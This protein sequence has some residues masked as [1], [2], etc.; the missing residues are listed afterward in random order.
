MKCHLWHLTGCLEQKVSTSQ[1]MRFDCL[2]TLLLT[3]LPQVWPLDKKEY[4]KI[5]STKTD[6][7]GTQKNLLDEK[8]LLNIQD[9]CLK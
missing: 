9:K 1:V 8:V 6:I 3:H 4:L 5:N 7:V 2:K